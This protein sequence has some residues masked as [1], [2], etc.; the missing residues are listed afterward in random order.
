MQRCIHSDAAISMGVPTGYYDFHLSQLLNI[1]NLTSSIMGNDQ[2][3]RPCFKGFCMPKQGFEYER[4]KESTKIIMQKDYIIK[5]VSQKNNSKIGEMDR[6]N[7][8]RKGKFLIH[9]ISPIQRI[10]KVKN[11]FIRKTNIYTQTV[12]SLLNLAV[13]ILDKI[14][15]VSI[16]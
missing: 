10:R 14:K 16:E 7:R 12:L 13:F 8:G 9:V 1:L 3:I 4:K 2:Q 11:N 6:G 5:F 15:S